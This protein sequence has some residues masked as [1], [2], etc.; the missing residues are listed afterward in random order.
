MTLPTLDR[1]LA[2][3]VLLAAAFAVLTQVEIWVFSTGDGFPLG[4]RVGAAI[5]VLVA[6]GALAWR[7][8]SPVFCFAMNSVAVVL[9]IAVGFSTDFYQWTNLV[10]T[11]SIAAHGTSMQSWV[12]LPF[13]LGGVSFYFF[14][15]STEGNLV[16]L[17][18]ALGMWAVAWM[19]G[20]TYGS[21]MAEARVRAE[22]D[23]SVELAEARQER[24][25]LDEAR[26]SIAR[27]LHDIIGHTVNVMVVHAGAGRGALPD[28]PDSAIEALRVIEETGRD[29]L[30]ELDQM[31]VLLGE[32]A[33]A[34]LSPPPGIDS[35]PALAERIGDASFDVDVV[36]NGPADVVPSRLG[37]A[38]YRIAQEALT[39][40]LKHSEATKASV[41]VTVVDQRVDVVVRDNGGGLPAGFTTGRGMAGM[42]ERAAMHGG[43]VEYR[44]LSEGLEVAGVLHW[45][46]Q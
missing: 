44:P 25:Y 39:N 6:S 12:A 42:E 9:A 22:R 38:V 36:I 33:Q 40:A 34:E 8:S 11:Y 4:V 43:H 26:A 15:F 23:V 27:E 14:R 3:D 45:R 13:S 5:C 41:E 24:I 18:F 10:A 7:R 28:D 37:L 35:L 21:R 1:P 31:L 46:D 16:I 29:A 30:A 2:T 17:G 32:N 19:A 20:R